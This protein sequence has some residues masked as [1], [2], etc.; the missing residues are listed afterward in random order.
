MRAWVCRE[1]RDPYE[2]R[3][4]S[5]PIPTPGPGQVLI[6]VAAAGLAFGETLVLKGQYQV[7]PPLP[8]V[9]SSELSGIVRAVGQGV[10]RFKPGDEVIAFSIAINGGAMAEWTLMP[11]DY[12]F[13]KPSPI[14]FIQAAALPINYWTAFNALT[15]RGQVQAGETVVV[16]GAT[17]GIGVAGIQIAKAI[18]A[19]VIAV[20]GDDDKLR[21]LPDLG[22]DVL[23]NHRTQDVRETIKTATG[24]LGADVFLDPVGGDLFDAAMRAIAPGGRILVVGATS[25]RYGQPRAG[26][27]LVKMIS[28]IG[29]EARLAIETTKGQGLADFHEMLRWFEEGRLVP[30]VGDVLPF[31]EALEGFETLVDRK[32]LGKSVLCVNPTLVA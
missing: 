6:E 26:V 25:G 10:T 16:F 17:G 15:R 1:Y 22:A 20:G 19:R 8:Y 27:M 3:M 4:E 12:V 21:A 7:T 24:G 11:E 13:L 18:G 29:V 2:L 31:E 9:P 23:I 32:H 30:H 28:V 14:D 5:L